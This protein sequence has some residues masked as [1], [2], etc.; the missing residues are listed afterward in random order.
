M[1]LL[2]IIQRYDK[3]QQEYIRELEQENKM[4]KKKIDDMIEEG[5]RDAEASSRS[6]FNAIMSGAIRKPE[7]PEKPEKP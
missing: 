4:L 5:M 1:S 3:D 7:K 6:L 2:K